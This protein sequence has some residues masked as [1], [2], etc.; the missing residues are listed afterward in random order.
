[1]KRTRFILIIFAALVAAAPSDAKI[2]LVPTSCTLPIPLRHLQAALNAR[3]FAALNPKELYP[4]F[5]EQT[6]IADFALI[7]AARVGA[8]TLTRDLHGGDLSSPLAL[9]KIRMAAVTDHFIASLRRGLP[10]ENMV[11]TGTTLERDSATTYQPHYH[12]GNYYLSFGYIPIGPGP[13]SYFLED[14]EMRI[15]QIPTGSI[16]VFNGLKRAA[17][18]RAPI[19]VH[20]SPRDWSLS[21]HEAAADAPIAQRMLQVTDLCWASG[22][23]EFRAAIQSATFASEKFHEQVFQFLG[24]PFPYKK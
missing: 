15:E 20:S 14:G 3:G 6:Y 19:S 16:F 22:E 2:L 18:R 24:I 12:G 13:W 1:M 17:L 9:A 10:G 5:D 21:T 7:A 8:M 4:E 11:K 23:L